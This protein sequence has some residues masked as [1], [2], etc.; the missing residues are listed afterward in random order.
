MD[1]FKKQMLM[2]DYRDLADALSEI[3]ISEYPQSHWTE[4]ANRIAHEEELF[5]NETSKLIPTQEDFEFRFTM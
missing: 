5:S 4:M 2:D 3:Q 1:D